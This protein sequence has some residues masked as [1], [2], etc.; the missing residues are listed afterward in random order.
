MPQLIV[1]AAKLNKRNRAP[2]KLPDPNGIIGTVYKGYTFEGI[3]CVTIPN[4]ALGKWYQDRDGSFYW[5]GGLVIETENNVINESI[6]NKISLQGLP[7]N[8]PANYRLGVDVSHLNGDIDWQAIKN[9]GASFVFIKI[10]D[11]VGTPDKR[12]KI[13]ADNAVSK[14]LRIG[15]YHFCRPD[16]KSGGTIESDAIAEANEALQIMGDLPKSDLPLMMD[17]ESWTTKEDSP[18]EGKDYLLWVTTFLNRVK[19][20]LKIDCIIY[21]NKNYLNEKL[22]A[23][24]GLGNY[25]LWLAA[26]PENPDCNKTACPNGWNDWAIWQYTG[27]GIIG[28]SHPIDINILKDNT[29]F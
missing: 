18:L 21:S 10:S 24:H 23:D 29:L 26:Y 11:G 14:N 1:T 15:Y 27:N 28:N 4:P 2:S 17:L 13:N 25:K 3:E 19:T 9:T 8:L 6:D 7:V 16:K 12:A 5:G 22:P 20:Q